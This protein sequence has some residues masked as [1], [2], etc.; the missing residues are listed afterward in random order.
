MKS[1]HLLTIIFSLVF[2]NLACAEQEQ[3]QLLVTP[4]KEVKVEEIDFENLPEQSQIGNLAEVVK[5]E[6]SLLEKLSDHIQGQLILHPYAESLAYINGQLCHVGNYSQS[7]IYTVL[8]GP[9]YGTQTTLAY[10]GVVLYVNY[11]YVME[12]TPYGVVL[13]HH[14]SDSEVVTGSNQVIIFN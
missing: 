5:S 10:N 14:Y 12:Y 2:V 1:F 11:D 3:S 8:E 9:Y 6:E 4:I 13:H 7:V